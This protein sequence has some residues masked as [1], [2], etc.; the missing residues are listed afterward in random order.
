VPLDEH[1]SGR[2]PRL[3]AAFDALVKAAEANGPVTI[4]ATKSR[5]TLQVRMR[6]AAVEPRRDRLRAHLV[7]KREIEHE[8]LTV[9][10]LEPDYYLHRFT[11]TTPDD[12]DDELKAWVAEAYRV[13]AQ[14]SAARQP[15]D[16]PAPDRAK[17]GSR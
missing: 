13:G 4:N 9:E 5:I 2:P 10:H 17:P 11:L 14:L 12:V 1:F 6:F 8:R 7:L 15:A 3:R 16:P